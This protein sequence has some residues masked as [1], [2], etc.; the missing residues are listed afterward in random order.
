MLAV[1]LAGG[2]GT[3]LKPHTNEIPK[4]LLPVGGKPIV[5]LLLGQM[6]KT[7]VTKVILA[8]NHLSEQITD[9]IGDGKNFGI[10]VEYSHEK[11]SLSTVGPIKLI[12]NLPENFIVANSDV[13]TDLSFNDIFE[14]HVENKAKLTIATY[15]RTNPTDFGVLTVDDD[16]RAVGF[17]EKP[18]FNFI[19][20][21]GVYV[22]NRSILS[23]VPENKQFGFDQLMYALLNRQVPIHT[24]PYSGYWLDIG[25]PDDY[26]RAN[27]DIER[28]K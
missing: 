25:R 14:N 9:T 22:F 1:V 21:M 26:Q 13:L 10:S 27:E 11:E 6:K 4:A 20:S 8:V 18:V 12:K 5:Q 19:V 23:F 24:Y 3:R 15:A 28:L 17:N 7:G 2:K 16:G